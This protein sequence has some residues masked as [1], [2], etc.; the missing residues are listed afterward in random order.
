M[1]NVLLQGKLIGGRQSACKGLQL[2]F[3]KENA[4]PLDGGTVSL[5]DG[6]IL[7]VF[8]DAARQTVLWQGAVKFDREKNRKPYPKK[9]DFDADY[10]ARG[11]QK[12]G[13]HWIDNAQGLQD[14]LEP[15]R[16]INM[17]LEGKSAT[18]QVDELSL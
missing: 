12:V 6:D 15:E 13:R 17:F 1:G 16:W 14:G 18:L 8:S 5:M 10:A 2:I 4:G 11:G 3:L 7:T 9:Y